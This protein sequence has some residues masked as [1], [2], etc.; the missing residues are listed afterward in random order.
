MGKKKHAKKKGKSELPNPSA[1]TQSYK[2]PIISK[3]MRE[4]EDLVPIPLI[5][6]GAIS[7]TAGGV[8]DAYYSSDPNSYGL[9]EWT[10]LVALYGEYRL[11]GMEV[12]FYPRD[13]Y[14][15]TSTVCMPLVVLVDR[16]APTFAL[17][18]Y[19]VAAS[20]ASARIVSLEDPW[21]EVAK[22]QNAEESQFI[23]TNATH[24]FYSVKFYAD[25]L[26]VSA[27]YGRAFVYLLI[28]F[29]GRR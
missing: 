26:S 4:A 20:H 24:A 5:F 27:N 23:A 2:G 19:Q 25:G 11:L 18:S 13:R 17:G 16:D 7:S 29:R 15:K 14:S 6:T 10:N 1:N 12:K 21:V 28:Q 3:A 8:I 9:S 22:M